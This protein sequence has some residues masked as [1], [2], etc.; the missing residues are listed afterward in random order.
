MPAAS[1]SA[2]LVNLVPT[3]NTCPSDN[4]LILFCN[5]AGQTGGYAFRA[6]ST[7]RQC[8]LQQ[9]LSFKFIQF[10]IGQ[11]GSPMNAG[12]TELVINVNNPISDSV[13]VI[14]GGVVLDRNDNTQISYST[15]VY[16]GTNISI[17]FNQGVEDSQTY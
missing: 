5:V 8:L 7:I 14:L 16:T 6:W 17:T 10:T 3:I 4:D 15:P 12:D 11:A 2:E 9:G 1:C 13:G